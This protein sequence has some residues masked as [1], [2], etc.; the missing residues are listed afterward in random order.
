MVA[1]RRM[2]VVDGS[3]LLFDRAR[4][5]FKH[6]FFD[7]QIDGLADYVGGWQG[8]DEWWP[9]LAAAFAVGTMLVLFLHLF[10]GDWKVR[11]R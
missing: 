9:Q 1:D 6:R 11:S 10:L 4:F 7:L 8:V 5:A 3:R 2:R